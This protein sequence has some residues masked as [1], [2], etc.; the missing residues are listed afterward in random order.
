MSKCERQDEE[1]S[2]RCKLSL[3]QSKQWS[4][5]LEKVKSRSRVKVNRFRHFR[6]IMK[7][8]FF[9]SRKKEKSCSRKHVVPVA[10]VASLQGR[11]SESVLCGCMLYVPH[12][13]LCGWPAASLQPRL[14]IVNHS[15]SVVLTASC[16]MLTRGSAINGRLVRGLTPPPPPPSPSPPPPVSWDKLQQP[17]AKEEWVRMDFLS[18]EPQPLQYCDKDAECGTWPDL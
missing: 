10:A 17:G 3:K 8:H 6:C 11:R 4:K 2:L 14:A 12:Q 9:F 13:G 15:L 16:C 1:A 5:T 18:S 7:L